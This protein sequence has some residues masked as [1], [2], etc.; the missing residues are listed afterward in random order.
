MSTEELWKPR[1]KVIADYPD[2]EDHFIIGEVMYG[3]RYFDLNIYY[4]P[5]P[6]LFKPLKWWEEREEKDMPEYLKDENGEVFRVESY[7]KN[8]LVNLYKNFKDPD[9]PFGW[10]N[11]Y[12]LLPATLEEYNQYNQ[13]GTKINR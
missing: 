5:Y 2:S 3:E 6:H 11:L 1:Y 9:F 4:K 7:S 10:H 12:E 8:S 13:Q